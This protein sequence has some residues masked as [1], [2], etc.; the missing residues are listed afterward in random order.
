MKFQCSLDDEQ[1]SSC[2]EGVIGQ[3]TGVNVPHGRHNFTVKGTDSI[4]NIVEAEVK[5]WYVDAIPPVITFN[6]PPSKTSGSAQF[7][8]RSSEQADFNC[9]FDGGPYK[10]CG[11]GA[12]GQWSKN[13]LPDGIHRLSVRGK[14]T[15]ENV[16]REATHIWTVG[17]IFTISSSLLNLIISYLGIS[18]ACRRAKI[19][20]RKA[21]YITECY[22]LCRWSQPTSPK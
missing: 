17:K 22:V 1:F 9:S 16:G 11:N 6:N 8:W 18:I 19:F 10:T 14:D 7:T 4:G 3:W 5:G 15:V 21:V 12:A 2:G 13:N 20:T